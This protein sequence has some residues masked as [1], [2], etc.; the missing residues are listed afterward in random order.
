[1]PTPFATPSATIGA[2]QCELDD[3]GGKPDRNAN[4]PGHVVGAERGAAQARAAAV[5]HGI[6]T[7]LVRNCALERV[8]QYSRDGRWIR[9]R[10]ATG[11]PAFARNASGAGGENSAPLTCPEP[12]LQPHAA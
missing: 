9:R 11:F 12:R 6:I 1:M 3:A 2:E 10:R 5:S 4:A 8:I 7:R